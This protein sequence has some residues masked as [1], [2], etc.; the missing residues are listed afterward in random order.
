MYVSWKDRE[1]GP[2]ETA[3][4]EQRWDW[5]KLQ[6]RQA[7]DRMANPHLEALQ[8]SS[9]NL[10]GKGQE[11]TTCLACLRAL[12]LKPVVSAWCCP[13]LCPQTP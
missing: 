1:M 9:F 13:R 5:L 11:E 8:P 12:E 6:R 4:S 2:Q 7:V 3:L 10:K